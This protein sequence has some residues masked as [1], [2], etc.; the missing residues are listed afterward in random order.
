[1]AL[2]VAATPVTVSSPGVAYSAAHITAT[3][4]LQSTSVS[5]GPGPGEVTATPRSQRVIFTTQRRVPR[6]GVMVVG[7]GGNNGSTLAAGL[8]ANRLG[9]SWRTRSGEQKASW[10]GSLTQ[11]ATVRLGSSDSGGGD[12]FV[13][14]SSLLP[15]V[16]PSDLYVGG[17]DIS[18][19]KMVKA[20]ER[21]QVL[22]VDLQRTLAPHNSSSGGSGDC[23]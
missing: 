11:S 9:L 4:D 20:V 14:F 12:V 2:F 5:L 22:D 15:M 3:V 17:W 6:T 21:A 18:S 1:M 13:P 16:A 7:L 8:L 23:R 19:L 10:L